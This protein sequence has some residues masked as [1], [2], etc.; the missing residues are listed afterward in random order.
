M[1]INARWKKRAIALAAA[2]TI[3][4]GGTAY[5]EGGLFRPLQESDFL[6]VSTEVRVQ[7]E[8]FEILGS[9]RQIKGRALDSAQKA[10]MFLKAEDGS[11]DSLT[12][13]DGSRQLF[14]DI[15]EHTGILL[16]GKGYL[17]N[18]LNAQMLETDQGIL[19]RQDF[20]DAGKNPKVNGKLY[21]FDRNMNL[22]EIQNRGGYI[23]VM[24]Y[25]DGVCYIRQHSAYWG[26]SLATA[27][28]KEQRT[29]VS[30]DLKTW[31]ED[32]NGNGV[33][34]TNGTRTLYVEAG[35]YQHPESGSMTTFVQEPARVYTFQSG[36]KQKEIC[37]ENP[38]IGD[39]RAAGGYFVALPP[40]KWDAG[41]A[42]RSLHREIGFSRDGVYFVRRQVPEEQGS[43]YGILRPAVLENG[44]ILLD[45][46]FCQ[47]LA[48]YEHVYYTA[49]PEALA[50]I[51]PE[52]PSYVAVGGKLLGFSVPPVTERDRI[53]VPMRFLFEKLGAQVSWDP[54][55]L[56]ATAEVNGQ[57]VT[58][59]IDQLT[60]WTGGEPAEMDVP[61]RL[62]QD[63]TMVPLRFLSE[64]LGY[65]VT[66]DEETR[67]ASVSL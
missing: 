59:F 34:M 65:T 49:A 19:L 58:F 5:G 41:H 33:P 61:A 53:L 62:I 4:Q 64:S 37:Y 55:K 13:A 51:T 60:V 36:R 10:E 22:R 44:K 32:P 2:L 45:L 25:A 8:V 28:A 47:D 46:M 12:I 67:T 50:E 57:T 3:A 9:T 56:G 54:E 29:M 24:G 21:L 15:T 11:W 30:S 14:D 38:E 42:A 7:G 52:A 18:R 26:T 27:F 1:K 43:G 6:P 31:T 16:S 48:Y 40:V 66:W 23:S 20:Y 63:K 17:L 35:V 39:I